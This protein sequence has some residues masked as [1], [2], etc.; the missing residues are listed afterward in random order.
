MESRARVRARIWLRVNELWFAA[1]VKFPLFSLF[2]VMYT[3]TVSD[4]SVK[5]QAKPFFKEVND[6]MLYNDIWVKNLPPK[7]CNM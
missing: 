3:K 4:L 5:L 2:I 1:V 6:N 7:G